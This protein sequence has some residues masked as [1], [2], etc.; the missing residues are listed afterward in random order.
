MRVFVAGATG[1]VGRRL[2]PQLIKAG[3]EV[4]G[5]TRSESKRQELWNAGA[6]PVVVDALDATAVGEAV[7]KAA[8]DVIVHQLTALSGSGNL[9]N[10]DRVFAGTNALRNRGTDNLIA[11]AGACGVR[12]FIAASY[13]GWPYARVGGSIKSETDPLDPHP[14]AQQRESLAAIKHLEEAT[15]S[16]PLTGVVLRYGMFYGPGAFDEMVSAVRKRMVPVVGD[17]GG[18]WSML[19]ID[20]AASAVVA[21]LDSG[22]GIYNIVDDDP[23]VAAELIPVLASI[24]GAKPPRHVPLWLGRLL[25]G[26][27]VSSML[28]QARGASNAKAKRELR[29]APTWPSWREGFRFGLSDGLSDG[30]ALRG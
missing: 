5:T 11:A 17:G 20:D 10:F 26:E 16:A 14:P 27:A 9:R 13:T 15:V 30:A 19:H 8:P 12:R 24:L 28:T 18:V 4:V 7:A 3:H 6:E 22:E 2:V 21:A 25:A 23:A 29:W 1:A